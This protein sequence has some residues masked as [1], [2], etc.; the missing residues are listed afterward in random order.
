[1][2]PFSQKTLCLRFG[3]Y[4]C[5]GITAKSSLVT[6]VK[7]WLPSPPLIN[8][9]NEQRNDEEHA[10]PEAQP[11]GLRRAERGYGST[12]GLPTFL[13]S[14]SSRSVR[15]AYDTI[16]T[17]IPERLPES[18]ASEAHS[19]RFQVVVWHVGPMDSV[20]GKVDVRFRVTI[21][22]NAIPYLRPCKDGYH[23]SSSVRSDT[24][25]TRDSIVK[26]W[27][28]YGRQRAYERTLHD[29]LSPE[30]SPVAENHKKSSRIRYVDVPPVSILNAIDF[31][32]LGGDPE[33]CV[34]QEESRLM[35][36]SCLY[37]ASLTQADWNVANFP[38]DSHNLVLKFGILKD[39]R[40]GKRWDRN[41]WKLGLA[42]EDDTQGSIRVPEGLLVEHVRVPE[43]SYDVA[44]GLDFEFVPLN[45][46]ASRPLNSNAENGSNKDQLNGREQDNCDTCLQVKLHVQRDSAYYDRNIIPLLT[47]LNLVGISTLALA[48]SK[49]GSRGQIIVATAFVEIGLRMTLDSRLPHVGYQ[50]K[51]QVVL[52]NFFFGLLF[53][54][55]GSSIN[56]LVLNY[57]MQQKEQEP[58]CCYHITMWLDVGLAITELLHV[59][60]NLTLYFGWN[61]GQLCD[62]AID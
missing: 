3:L 59:L 55:L 5:S 22:W 45:F 4:R 46:G 9:H 49:F 7:L 58:R 6:M 29:N 27:T 33:V 28:M 35:R 38:H 40:A 25:N 54:V 8:A 61:P 51:M 37:K 24:T 26:V 62:Y 10:S 16:A 23:A 36:W 21:F 41:I 30:S 53:L 20:L 60:W 12:I 1:M 2:T 15:S 18:Q 43:F 50:I 48:P 14:S 42:T 57:D 11:F 34:V 56:Y 13:T 19:I 44:R 32:V 52:N 39:R 47:A 31:E 17:S